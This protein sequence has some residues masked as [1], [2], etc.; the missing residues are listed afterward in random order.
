MCLSHRIFYSVTVNFSPNNFLGGSCLELPNRGAVLEKKRCASIVARVLTTRRSRVLRSARA[1][2]GYTSVISLLVLLRNLSGHAKTLPHHDF[3][4]LVVL[5]ALYVCSA[6]AM[7]SSPAKYGPIN[8]ASTNASYLPKH[9]FDLLTC[10]QKAYVQPNRFELQYLHITKRHAL[11]CVYIPKICAWILIILEPLTRTTAMRRSCCTYRGVLLR[12][13]NR[14]V[15][16]CLPL[17]PK[18]N[19]NWRRWRG[20]SYVFHDD[21]CRAAWRIQR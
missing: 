5:Y 13:C 21:Q 17:S 4:F 16:Q 8:N 20:N 14:S 19:V 15:C 1:H 2:E 6:A 7:W 11:L 3:K 18:F 12:G 10:V 9:S